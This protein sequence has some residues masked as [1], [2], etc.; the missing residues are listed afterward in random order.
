MTRTEKAQ[1]SAALPI[2]CPHA[3]RIEAVN[4]PQLQGRAR[5]VKEASMPS[6]PGQRPA[7]VRLRRGERR[8]GD[9]AGG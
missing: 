2:R 4:G 1:A 7:M 5:F 6:G 9:T 3:H 8:R